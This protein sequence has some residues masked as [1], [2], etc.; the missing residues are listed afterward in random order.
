MFYFR[1][2]MLLCIPWLFKIITLGRKGYSAIA[3]YPFII[4]RLPRTQVDIKLINHEKIHHRQQIELLF[5]FFAIA[6]FVEFIYYFI[7]FKHWN[8]AY[9]NIS[10][11][12]EAYGF[13][14]NI[15]YLKSRKPYAQW[16]TTQSK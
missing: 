5:V 4:T 12:K 8:T 16:R 7:K 3:I 9:L 6:Y 10:F 15:N 1:A 2:A 14:T 13:Q 11:E